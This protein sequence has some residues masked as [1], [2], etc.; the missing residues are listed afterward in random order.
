MP[1]SSRRTSS[2]QGS[3][4]ELHKNSSPTF[5]HSLISRIH[6]HQHTKDRFYRQ[7]MTNMLASS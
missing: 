5:E 1:G 2:G 4:V 3:D 6:L 7:T